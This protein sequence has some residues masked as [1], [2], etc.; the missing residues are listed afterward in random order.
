MGKNNKPQP[1]QEYQGALSD[2]KTASP[3]QSKLQTMALNDLDTLGKGDYTNLPKDVFFNFADPAQRARQ[4]SLSY[5]QKGQGVF[6]LGNQAANPTALGLAKQNIAAHDAQDDATTYEGG[7]KE[8][9]NRAFLSAG[10]LANMDQARKLGI[11]GIT[12][13]PYQ[14]QVNKPSWFDRILQGASAGAGA[15]AGASG[16]G[17]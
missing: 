2:A 17:G 1:V 13:G 5:N 12:S 6:G 7:V 3:V 14:Q 11:L 4:R 16:G 9:A 15:F 10:D 8:A